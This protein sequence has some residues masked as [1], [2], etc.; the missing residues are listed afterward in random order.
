MPGASG[1]FLVA[2]VPLANKSDQSGLCFTSS[3]W[4]ELRAN[5][6]KPNIRE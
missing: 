3:M 2:S 1:P 6:V 5:S 4:R